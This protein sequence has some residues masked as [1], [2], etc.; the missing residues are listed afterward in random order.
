[1]GWVDL[2][3]DMILGDAE[4]GGDS[5][6]GQG[7]LHRGSDL[8]TEPRKGTRTPPGEEGRKAREFGL[9]PRNSGDL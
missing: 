7:R 2:L 8:S 6:G 3:E 4:E 9:L 5:M 1:M